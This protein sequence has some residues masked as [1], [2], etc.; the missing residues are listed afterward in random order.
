MTIDYSMML[1]IKFYAFSKYP[2]ER[3]LII[4]YRPWDNQ[5]CPGCA[6]GP[7]GR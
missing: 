2:A 3:A 6:H 1:M 4:S 5:I 7:T